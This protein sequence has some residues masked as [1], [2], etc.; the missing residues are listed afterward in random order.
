MIPPKLTSPE[1]K[2]R[3]IMEP[4]TQY[5]QYLPQEL[6]AD[7][8]YKHKGLEHPVATLLKPYIELYSP[9]EGD[10]PIPA[11]WIAFNKDTAEVDAW[12][13]KIHKLADRLM[14]IWH[15]YVEPA[16]ETDEVL[17]VYFRNTA[18]YHP[19]VGFLLDFV[20]TEGEQILEDSVYELPPQMLG[21]MQFVLQNRGDA[22]YPWW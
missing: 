2:C 4:A 17:W 15:Q 11:D 20:N 6:V 16:P 10:T 13:D 18:D 12:E 14:A 7:I 19:C 8:L 21:E 1:S 5:T 22:D 3:Y 9:W